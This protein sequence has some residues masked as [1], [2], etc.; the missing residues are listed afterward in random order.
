MGVLQ[1]VLEEDCV[2]G[3]PVIRNAYVLMVTNKAK[4]ANGTKMLGKH[5]K[6]R[7]HPKKLGKHWKKKKTPKKVKTRTQPDQ[8]SGTSLPS[9][10]TMYL[11]I[12]WVLG[13]TFYYYE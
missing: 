4:L 13:L 7:R 3:I 11:L 5:W 10:Q 9:F 12:G 2:I 6:K 8:M 1:I